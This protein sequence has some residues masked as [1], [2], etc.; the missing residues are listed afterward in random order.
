MKKTLLLCT[1][2]LA[3]CSCSPAPERP[4]EAEP[5][6]EEQL[7]SIPDDGQGVIYF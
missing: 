6:Q 5:L 1:L 7:E 4:E 3:A 2:L